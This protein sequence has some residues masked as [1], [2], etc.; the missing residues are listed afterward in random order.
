MYKEAA[1]LGI[2][3]MGYDSNDSAIKRRNRRKAV[4]LL[5]TGQSVP[6][7]L[8]KRLI[9]KDIPQSGK[10][11]ISVKKCGQIILLVLQGRVYRQECSIRL[12]SGM[13]DISQLPHRIQSIRSNRWSLLFVRR[14]AYWVGSDIYGLQNIFQ[15]VE[16][17]W[18]PGCWK[19]KR[20]YVVVQLLSTTE[21]VRIEIAS[22]TY[23]NY[24]LIYLYKHFSF[25][26]IFIRWNAKKFQSWSA[27]WYD[28]HFS[29]LPW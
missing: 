2:D 26:N 24:M 5:G 11:K 28:T 10:K 6:E 17:I 13:K 4:V 7:K 21:K 18:K 3:L 27:R 23:C 12:P 9:K 1:S 19:Q 22:F 14:S 29:E 8:K 20:K 15:K 16:R 25:R